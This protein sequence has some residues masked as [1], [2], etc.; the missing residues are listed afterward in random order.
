M[1]EET[2]ARITVADM[3][4]FHRRTDPA[5]CRARVSIVGAV[6]RAAGA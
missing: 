1:T 2:L 4:R 5:A 6:N 3:Q